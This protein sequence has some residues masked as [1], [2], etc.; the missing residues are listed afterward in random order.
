VEEHRSDDDNVDDELACV[1]WGKK[2]RRLCDFHRIW[3]L[4]WSITSQWL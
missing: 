4:C 3:L 1:K 2:R